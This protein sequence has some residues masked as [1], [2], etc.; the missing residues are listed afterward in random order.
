M[1]HVLEHH[2]TNPLD[3]KKDTHSA[4]N[5]ALSGI[6]FL[7]ASSLLL[8][9]NTPITHAATTG[10]YLGAGAGYGALTSE[11]DGI[12]EGR[13]GIAGRVFAG[14]NFNS[15]LGIESNFSMLP[16]TRYQSIDYPDVSID[17][18][19]NALS[20]VVKGYLPVLKDDTLNVYSLV[21]GAELYANLDGLYQ[22]NAIL[23]DSRSAL[24]PTFGGG[25]IYKMTPNITA[26]LEYAVFAESSYDYSHFGIPESRLATAH[27]SYHF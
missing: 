17:Y 24:V 26:G 14:Y 7:G 23:S 12:R 4:I 2:N 9:L 27:L 3:N 18:R 1:N 6:L 20:L 11:P 22:F 13:G 5:Q 21:G 25:V 16:K 8:C 19:V 15:Y 10:A